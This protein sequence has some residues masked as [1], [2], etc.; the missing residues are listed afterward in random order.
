MILALGMEVDPDDSPWLINL[1][2]SD[3][4]KEE[5]RF[6]FWGCFYNYIAQKSLSD[7]SIA[8]E[9]SADKMRIG[10]GIPGVF[11]SG[12][13]IVPVCSSYSLA[14]AIRKHHSTVPTSLQDII[15]SPSLT[16]LNTL[17]LSIPAQTPLEFLFIS[18]SPD[19]ISQSDYD[20]FNSLA[21]SIAPP[22]LAFVFNMNLNLLSSVSLFYRPQLYL[23]ALPSCHPS[24]IPTNTRTSIINA[25]SQCLDAAKRMTTLFGYILAVMEAENAHLPDYRADEKRKG[26]LMMVYPLLECVIV[27]WFVMCR[28]DPVWWEYVDGV[29][30][31]DWKGGE[32][33]R[34]MDVVGYVAGVYGWQGSGALNPIVVCM[35]AMVGEIERR[36]GG[37]AGLVDTGGLELAMNV[38]SIGSN[39]EEAK[40]EP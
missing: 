18:E 5:R 29:W 10:N 12:V 32:R 31:V 23:S 39:V 8:V 13:T 40:K 14:S 26:G 11:P 3:R 20:R 15:S 6:T 37:G 35:E 17:L 25:I 28:M 16:D 7:D 33:K 36:V 4:Q 38:A 21:Q 2:L 34:V 22:T 19:T 1:K 27:Y 24:R 30:R 9:I